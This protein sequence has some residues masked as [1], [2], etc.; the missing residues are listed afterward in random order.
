MASIRRD[1]NRRMARQKGVK[2]A[3]RA[4]AEQI[5]D[6]AISRAEQHRSSGAFAR[7]LHIETGRTD[8]LVVAD[9]P[10]A[11]AKEYGHVD[12]DTGRPVPGIHAL[13]G[14]VADVVGR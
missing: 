4:V 14:A 8:A 3:V 6:A 13:G 1:L 9:D 12:P 5:L 10:L 2:A 7:S 11:I